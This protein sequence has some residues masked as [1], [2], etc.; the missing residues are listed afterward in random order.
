MLKL[1][2]ELSDAQWKDLLERSRSAA[3]IKV[4]TPLGKQGQGLENRENPS[5]TG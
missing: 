5:S 4:S 3:R 2:I 1:I